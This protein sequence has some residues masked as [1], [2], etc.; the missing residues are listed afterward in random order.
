MR[1]KFLKCLLVIELLST[2]ILAVN[3]LTDSEMSLVS[4]ARRGE[5]VFSPDIKA[6]VN[7]ADKEG[8]YAHYGISDIANLNTEDRLALI[9]DLR[10]MLNV[11]D[12]IMQRFTFALYHS[13]I[14]SVTANKILLILFAYLRDSQ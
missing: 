5:F 1:L 7:W 9:D 12:P 14:D 13:T 4:H 2:Q 6:L 3:S 10:S 8:V 11:E